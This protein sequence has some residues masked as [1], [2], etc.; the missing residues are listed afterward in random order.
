[1]TPAVRYAS[2]LLLTGLLLVACSGYMADES[3]ATAA[4]DGSGS[5]PA[6]NTRER[7]QRGFHLTLEP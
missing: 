5:T 6:R 3:G 7:W 2:I 4:P 1:M